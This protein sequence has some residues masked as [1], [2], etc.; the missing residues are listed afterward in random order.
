MPK[1]QLTSDGMLNGRPHRFTLTHGK[2]RGEVDH[3]YAYFE[4]LGRIWYAET[5]AGYLTDN[6][7]RER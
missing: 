1:A 4:A 2:G 3:F 6:A 7:S 5:G